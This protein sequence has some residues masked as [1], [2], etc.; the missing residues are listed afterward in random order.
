MSWR[1]LRQ[2]DESIVLPWTGGRSLRSGARVWIIDGKRPD[3]PGWYEFRLAGR[4]ARLI[5]EAIINEANLRD[6]AKGYLIGDRLVPDGTRVDPDPLKISEQ[7]EPV[8]LIEPGLDRFARIIAGRSHDEGPLIFIR[9]DFPLGPED[10]VLQAF[11]TG[12]TSVAHVLEVTPALDAAFRMEVWQRVEAARRRAELERIRK[13]EEE[14]L[15]K[16][17]RRARLAEQIGTGAGRRAMAA[18]DFAEAARAALAAGGAVYLDH[19][20]APRRNEMVVTFQVERRQYEC[21][22][23]ALR[24]SIIDAGICLTSHATGVKYDNQL[25]L[26]SLPGVIRQAIQEGKLVVFRHVGDDDD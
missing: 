6:L 18:V 16:E 7:S 1:E 12:Q 21:V 4:Q 10:A 17:E 24:L 8:L 15:A 14:R 9:Q 13:E 23:D 19:R 3:N 11:R 25:T 22:C 5:G 20:A 26:E 2:K